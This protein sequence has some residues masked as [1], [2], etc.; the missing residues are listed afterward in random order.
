MRRGGE[1]WGGGRGCGCRVGVGDFDYAGRKGVGWRG[2]AVVVGAE[3][4]HEASLRVTT[5]RW[6]ILGRELVHRR[7]VAGT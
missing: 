3:Q 7:A 4:E 2:G 1:G 5:V 6:V